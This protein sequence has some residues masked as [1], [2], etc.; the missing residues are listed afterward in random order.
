MQC[1]HHPDRKAEHFCASC[2]I[3]LCS[4]CTEEVER[5]QFY[6]FQCAMFQ[7]VSG[8]GTTLKDKREKAAE[9]RR[10]DR[11]KKKW[12]PFRYFVITALVLILVMWGVILFGGQ[13]APAGGADFAKNQR[14]FLFMVDGALKRHAH[15]E[16]N[17]YPAKLSDLVPKYLSLRE[18][19]FIHLEKLSY[20]KD[21]EVGYRLSLANPKPGEMIII[22]SPQGI[23]HKLPA[24]GG[25]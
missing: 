5:G 9:K 24:S 15:Y 14:A 10:A 4:Q 2:N 1:K 11:E 17:S 21:P 23:E 22:M 7:T 12:G 16:N 18:E 6:C 3:P 20:N 8:V 13:K 19:D 25:A